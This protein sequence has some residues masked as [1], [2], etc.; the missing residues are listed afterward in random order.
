MKIVLSSN[1]SWS[2]YNFRL[3]L[4]RTLKEKGYKVIIVS[5]YDKY[6]DKLS[7]EFEYYNIFINRKGTNPIEDLKT[8]L[9]YYKIYK[10][11][12]PDIALHYTVKPNIY[13]TFACTL[14]G[15]K[16]IVSITGLGYPFTNPGLVTKIV[17]LLYKTALSKADIVLFQ[18]KS[19]YELFIRERLVDSSKCDIL[20]GSG[21]DTQFFSPLI[22]EKKDKIFRFLLIARML[23]DKGIGEY[24]EAA[25]IIK[26]KYPNVE[27]FL[28]G[29]ID[30]GNPKAISQIQIEK[31]E[32]EGIIKYLGVREKED[33]KKEIAKADCVVLP[34]YY[35]EGIPKI[36][37][38]A[39]SMET[40]VIT[41][42]APG[43]REV[44]D[45]GINGFL[46][47]PKDSKDLAEKMEKMMNL[48]EEERI[49]MGKKGRE[50]VIKCFD[51]RIVIHK[52]LDAINKIL[53][54]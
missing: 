17:K 31:W 14:L 11:V 1:T 8:F 7:K 39:A 12:K 30:E 10:K 15:I 54:S 21:V 20:P 50:K 23:W 32:K 25:R 46:C 44:V 16:T 38:E 48:P 51:E 18:N 40:P 43:C 3:N 52:Y 9:M 47:K 36:L 4:A 26:S 24:V 28:M 42:D 13:G 29:A 37:L 6:S 45:D 49:K 5:P 22:I 2:I 27:F 34:S 41:T 19:D 33:V 53:K 35:R